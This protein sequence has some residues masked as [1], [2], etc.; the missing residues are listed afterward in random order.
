MSKKFFYF[1]TGITLATGMISAQAQNATVATIPQGMI[2]YNLPEGTTSVVGLP[3][4]NDVEFT[5]TVTAVTANTISVGGSSAPFTS[6]LATTGAP[7]FVKFLSGSE[8]GRVILITS[9]TNSTL[10]L[11]TT[12]NSSQ[13]VSLTTSG[14][15]VAVGDVFEIFTGDTLASIFGAN[16]S[17]SPL[18]LVGS[19]SVYTADT[20][21]VYSPIQDRFQAYFFNTSAGY[22][23]RSGST[24]NANNTIL[25]PYCSLTVLRRASST[26][27][28]LVL[29]GR[30]AEVP[31][32]TKTTGNN[33]VVYASTGYATDM[34]LSDLQ[35][36]SNW[37]TSTS[38][39][40]ADTIS[41]WNP[42]VYHFEAYYQMPD[43]TWRLSNNASTD[44]SGLVLAAGG[45]ISIVQRANVSGASSFL[46]TPMPYS[47]N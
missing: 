28:T 25:Y 31:V 19:K 43:S 27:S 30:V 10:T 8:M 38:A 26:A 35:F 44:Q 7:Y 33:S 23:E 46:Q 24:A 20:V 39:A 42:T 6:N 47:L 4:T 34:T 40:K 9:N 37:I 16:T 32:L 14:F 21:G 1:L 41:V 12:D 45:S 36:G 29:S 2:T 5:S 18:V 17:Q 11:D 13:T 3:L 15:S 22:W